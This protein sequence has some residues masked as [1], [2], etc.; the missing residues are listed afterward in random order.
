MQLGA[1]PGPGE[2]WNGLIDDERVYTRALSPAEV[3]A[4][5]NAGK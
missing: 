4:L 2:C 3:A 1:H 5:Y